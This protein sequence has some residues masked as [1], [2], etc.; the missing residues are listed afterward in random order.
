MSTVESDRPEHLDV[1]V[2]GAGLS[3]IAA[4]HHLQATCPEATYAIFEARDAIGG[5]WD[6]FRYPGVRSDS[7]MYTLGYSFRPWTGEDAI[8]DGDAI[9]DYIRDTAREEGID[10]KIRFGHRVLRADW[11]TPDACWHVT[12]ENVHTGERVELTAGFVFSCSGYYR[13][14]RGHFPDFEGLDTFEGTVVHPQE[15]PED[16]DYD[17]KRVVVIGSGATAVT[18]VPAM[19][20]TA[21]HVTM[22]QRSPSYVA[23]APRAS[24]LAR[25]VQAVVPARWEGSAVRW[26]QALATQAMFGFCRWRPQLAKR[27]L[28]AGVKAELPDGYDV[29]THFTPQYEPWDQ[30]LCLAADGDFFRA[31]RH[32][33]ASVVTDQIDTFTPTG[34]RLASGEELEADIVVSATGL[35]LLFLGGIEATVDGEGEVGHV[36]E[37]HPLPGELG[38]QV[39]R[40]PVD[41]GLD[42][43]QEQ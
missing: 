13:Y 2:V 37:H 4:G 27:L 35:E 34:V 41:G 1:L 28:L 15:W 16:L 43:T 23:A 22:L 29:E 36:L 10:E 31:I 6:L 39:D 38:R 3:G 26:V 19:A 7:D 12:A 11:S 25:L 5:T 17:G 14:D 32:G 9:L 8:A 33:S 42:A 40:L 18:L 20:E 30:R 24:R 21:G